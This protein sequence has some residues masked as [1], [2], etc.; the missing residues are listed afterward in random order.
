[1]VC[2]ES[3]RL[4]SRNHN[5]PSI[6]LPAVG[7]FPYA[8]KIPF[9]GRSL[10]D[11]DPGG[12]RC[13]ARARIQF[14]PKNSNCRPSASFKNAALPGSGR[15]SENARVDQIGPCDFRNHLKIE[16]SPIKNDRSRDS[17]EGRLF[18][19]RKRAYFGSFFEEIPKMLA[20]K[21]LFGPPEKSLSSP[22][23]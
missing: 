9:L 15:T 11:P 10:P 19:P 23:L 7:G 17:I 3:Q 13:F 16:I 5:A 18:S 2:C 12:S 4:Y 8:R 20:C 22:Q 6:F 1:M 14:G 21:P